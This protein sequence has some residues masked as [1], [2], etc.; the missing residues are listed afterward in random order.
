MNFDDLPKQWLVAQE[1]PENCAGVSHAAFQGWQIRT[2]AH[3]PVLSLQDADGRDLGR[4]IGWTILD[5]TLYRT[6]TTL[7]LAAGDTPETLY[8]RMG[9]RF[10][11]LWQGAAG[12]ILMRED[13]AG[14]LPA[15][16][17][18]GLGAV[19]STVTALEM[20]GK[21][22]PNVDAIALFEFPKNKG[23]LPFGLTPR[24]QA[25][26]LMPNHTLDLRHFITLRAWP[27]MDYMTRANMSAEDC[28]AAMA[29]TV[30][31]VRSHMAAIT[32]AQGDTVLY[33]SGGHDSRMV[34]AAASAQ[35]VVDHLSF[36]TLTTKGGLDIHIA[37]K[38]AQH[39]GRPH[40]TIIVRPPSKDEQADWITRA[41][42]MIYDAV[43]DMA[44]T[45]TQHAPDNHPLSGTGAEIARG[46][47]WTAED[48]DAPDMDLTTLLQRLRIPDTP[49]VRNAGQRWL[50]TVPEHADAAM[51]LDLAKI[52]QIHA[53]WSGAAIYGH[54]IDL[55]T[56]HPFSGHRLNEIL[57]ALPVAYRAS[58]QSYRDYVAH[59]APAM[60]KIP[61]N[62]A[63]G[64][65]RLKF[66]KEELKSKVP[67]SVKRW[68]K[69]FR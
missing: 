47:N 40:K 68:L 44:T 46:S 41:G 25:F 38:L 23:F 64:L 11:M 19:G 61:V 56:L 65:D 50:E 28:R 60:G 7:T 21:M 17:A 12:E 49:A 36:E 29:Q 32:K 58:G 27:D 4:V 53:C 37:E 1:I 6:D 16:Y 34:L 26:R 31:I 20:L 3:V 59:A 22:T 62:K 30:E 35:G 18:K 33:L 52:E 69:P 39:L 43:T 63:A 13:S 9:G 55:P 57:L 42:G 67:G 24:A 2:A 5:G 66:W 54:P 14:N 10:V 15:V 8:I 45:M 51:I 48:H